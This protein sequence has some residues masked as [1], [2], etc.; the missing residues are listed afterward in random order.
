MDQAFN[1][2][3]DFDEY[4]KIGDRTH[5]AVHPGIKRITLGDRIP[6]VG[7]SLLDAEADTF[8]LNLDSQHDGFDFVALLIEFR[9]MP[10][11]LGPRQ[12]GDMDQAVNARFNFDKHA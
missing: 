8:L 10:H 4:A 12:I 2:F 3:L 5:R 1:T 11:F 9:W 6:W 7:R